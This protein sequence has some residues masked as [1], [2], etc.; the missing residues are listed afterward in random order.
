M[1]ILFFFRSN[2]HYADIFFVTFVGTNSYL[3]ALLPPFVFRFSFF[4][5]FYFSFQIFIVCFMFFIFCFRVSSLFFVFH[6]CFSYF[7]LSFSYFVLHFRFLFCVFRF[8]IEVFYFVFFIF[9]FHCSF[10][11]FLRCRSA[12]GELRSPALV[13]TQLTFEYWAYH[14]DQYILLTKLM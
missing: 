10:F 6:L 1:T 2:R 7:I 8:S 14:R 11:I 9:D 5:L 13:L 3:L 12:P 4:V